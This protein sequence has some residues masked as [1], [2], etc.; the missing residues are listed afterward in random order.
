[1]KLTMVGTGY[2]GLV[3]GACLADTG[4][5]VTCLDIDQ[6][7]IDMLNRGEVPIYEPGLEAMIERNRS[8]GRLMFTTDKK[9]AY[10]SAEGI[11]ICVGTPPDEDGSAD[12]KH[13]L[14]A[15]ADIA[16]AIDELGPD[17]PR[18]LVVVKS[19]VP[20]GSTDKVRDAIKAGT[21]VPF[22]IADNPEF[23]KEGAAVSDFKKPDRVICGVEDPDAAE[24]IRDLYE[25]FVRQGNPMFI[26]V[27]R[28]AEMVKYASKAMLAWIQSDDLQ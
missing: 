17:S 7:K 8:A 3:T 13:V 15:A 9:A 26:M 6:D 18:K 19:T 4:N 2:V 21:D 27:V 22:Y 16:E 10:R 23:L 1:M 14:A 28:S 20:V 25:P 12:L 11:F 5:T 24:I